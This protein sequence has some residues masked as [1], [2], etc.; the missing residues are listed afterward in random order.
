MRWHNFS[1]PRRAS[2]DL[3][4]QTLG[5]WT[6]PCI[7]H[8][9]GRSYSVLTFQYISSLI[10]INIII[11]TLLHGCEEI[12]YIMCTGLCKNTHCKTL[13]N[14]M[15]FFSNDLSKQYMTMQP[16]GNT[17]WWIKNIYA[18]FKLSYM[19][20]LSDKFQGCHCNTI[21][22]ST[23]HFYSFNYNKRKSNL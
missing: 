3:H 10:Y 8:A 1:K 14:S 4:D 13:I 2:L 20:W 19:V 21:G 15:F 18:L 23:R 9:K 6:K 22:I 17:N 5:A 16:T 11:F 12:I 7:K